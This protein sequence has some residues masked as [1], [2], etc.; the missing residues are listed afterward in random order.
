MRVNALRLCTLCDGVS[1]AAVAA[2]VGVVTLD[3]LDDG[4]LGLALT[5][6]LCGVRLL[7]HLAN[8]GDINQGDN[9][10]LTGCSLVVITELLMCYCIHFKIHFVLR[11]MFYF[12]C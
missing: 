7:A 5:E 9:T 10:A 4:A 8:Q 1:E 2:G 12:I 6:R 11:Q 3:V